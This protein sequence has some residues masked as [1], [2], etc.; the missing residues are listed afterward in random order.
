MIVDKAPDS[1]GNSYGEYLID[2]LA[3]SGSSFSGKKMESNNP[4]LYLNTAYDISYG[5]TREPF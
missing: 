5:F 3:Y 2:R 4:N 1:S